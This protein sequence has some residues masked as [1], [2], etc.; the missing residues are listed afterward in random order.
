V[1]IAARAAR[2]T[3][4][5]RA[6]DTLELNDAARADCIDNDLSGATTSALWNALR[7]LVRARQG[8]VQ[9]CRW[10]AKLR[11]SSYPKGKRLV[12][13]QTRWQCALTALQR[14]ARTR[15]ER[16]RVDIVHTPRGGSPMRIGTSFVGAWFG[17]CLCVY[18]CGSDAKK[19][20]AVDTGDATAQ[21]DAPPA[22]AAVSPLPSTP[23]KLVTCTRSSPAMG[24][25]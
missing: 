22:G 20:S 15:K 13:F 19:Q 9:S 5:T 14:T 8:N 21:T 2:V 24:C 3:T 4:A 6:C 7:R 10:P 25:V 23:P 1:A 11:G 16:R 12:H 18:G 17:A